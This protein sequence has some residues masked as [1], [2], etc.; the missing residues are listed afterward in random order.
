MKALRTIPLILAAMFAVGGAIAADTVETWDVGATDVD[1]YT[2]AENLGLTPE[3]GLVFGD[4]MLGYGLVDR[5]SAY[6]GMT[7]QTDRN[8]G[9]SDPMLYLGLFG[10]PFQSDHVDLDLFLD[11]TSS[12]GE[13][14]ITPSLEL[15]WDHDPDM[16]TF[17]LYVRTGIVFEQADPD[18]A[19]PDVTPGIGQSVEVNP[20]VYWS[21]TERSQLLVEYS[22]GYF[23][24]PAAEQDRWDL[25][26]L[27]LGYNR[28]L[29]D[30]LELITEVN[31]TVDKVDGKT[32]WGAFAGIIV[33][34]PSVR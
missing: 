19:S 30:A 31:F 26:H 32:P 10:T 21:V 6:A 14:S 12:G 2:G 27:H 3:E 7:F 17:G 33:T 11:F 28:T 20:G 29:V 23:P 22:T 4:I 15:N 24:N 8:L 13:A 18:P 5:L 16:A 34:M 25:S 1:F 9:Q